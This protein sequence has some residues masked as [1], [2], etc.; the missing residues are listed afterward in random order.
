MKL[1]FMQRVIARAAT[2]AGLQPSNPGLASVFG[3]YSLTSS[4]QEVTATTSLNLAVYFACIRNISEDIAALPVV[5]FQRD[6]D[7]KRK[8]DDAPAHR[9]L[10]VE[11]N[12]EMSGQTLRETLTHHA[13][14]WGNG[15]AE[16]V[17]KGNGE[18][19]ELWPITPD[20]VTVKR[21]TSGTLYYDVLGRDNR[22][23]PIPAEDMLHVKGLSFDGLVGYSVAGYARESIGGGLAMDKYAAAF[24]GNSSM[25]SVIIKHPL[26]LK[27]DTKKAFRESWEEM[28]RGAEKAHKAAVLD[29]GMDVQPLTINQKDSQFIESRQHNIEDVCRWFRMPPH[30]VQHLLRA[31]FTNIEHQGIEYVV[32]TLGAWI[33]RWETEV[34]RKLF[35]PS[36]RMAWGF[37]H[38][39]S[40]LLRGDIQARFTA[41]AQARQWGWLSVNDIRKLENDDP[42]EGGDTYLSPSN[43]V[44]ADRLDDIVDS[45]IAGKQQPT[46]PPG[47]P[48]DQQREALRMPIIDTVARMIRKEAM[49]ARTA[50]KKPSTFTDWLDKFVVEHKAA[51]NEALAP[52][53]KPWNTFTATP[54]NAEQFVTAHI[55][56]LRKTLD[57]ALSTPLDQFEAKITALTESWNSDRAAEIVRAIT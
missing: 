51:M 5:A 50:A 4:G 48:T 10:D 21:S 36:Q 52:H 11:P 32:Y 20:R 14:G 40:G 19:V 26:K 53:V 41:Y 12:P 25:P 8:D 13:L 18:P 47:Q 57:D 55:E 43:M 30:M 23:K 24:F 33:K 15:Y 31:T 6:G 49:Q 29:E 54:I 45:Q 39:V 56:E 42:V 17:R 38:N 3:A 46:P 1:S 34:R 28:H 2:W 9:L 16:I 37:E 35:L 22:T 27:T 7:R 44:P